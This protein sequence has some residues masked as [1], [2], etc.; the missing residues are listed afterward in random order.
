MRILAGDGQVLHGTMYAPPRASAWLLIN[1]AMGVRRRFYRH[2]AAHL[3][4]Q[5]IGV[6]TYDYRGMGDS[7]LTGTNAGAARLEDWGRLDFPGAL[8]WLRSEHAPQRIVVL[9]HSVGGQLLGIAPEVCAVDALVGVASPSGH[10]RH[11]SGMQRAVVFGLWYGAVPLLTR[12]YGRFPASRLGLGQDLPAGIA[13][14]WAQWGRD[15]DYLRST[16]VGPQ[17]QYHDE[18]R[19]RLRTYLV[20]QDHLAAER[21]VMAW[22]DWFPNAERE[23]VNLGAHNQAGRKIGHFGFFDPEIGGTEWP[24][25]TDFVRGSAP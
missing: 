1:S 4:E 10:W 17:P 9:G 20:E 7:A 23:L 14:Q 12:L 2:I 16:A 22:H 19:C 3:A 21:A 24:G 6:L 5:G 8:R 18:V 13:R 11:W 25:L 15:P